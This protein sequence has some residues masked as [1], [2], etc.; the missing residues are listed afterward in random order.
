MTVAQT[1]RSQLESVAPPAK[2]TASETIPSD[3]VDIPHKTARDAWFIM[4]H[5]VLEQG[6]R[7]LDVGC[8]DGA[9]TYAMA[10]MNPGMEYIGLDPDKKKIKSAQDTYRLP[11]LQFLCGDL[12]DSFIPRQSIDA[13]VNAFTLYEIFSDA[14]FS[15]KAVQNALQ[16]QYDLLKPDGQ[17]VIRDHAHP[18]DKFILMEMPDNPGRGSTIA[19][20][21]EPDLLIR[22]SQ[23][24]RS[25]QDESYR[26]FYLEEM[27]ARFPRTRL[28]RLPAKWA[29]EFVLRKN[30]R[31]KWDVELQKE[32][33]FFTEQEYRRT[34]RGLGFRVLYT[35]PHWDPQ[36]VQNRFDKKFKLF[37]EDGTPLGPP[38]TSFM[39]VAVKAA[40]RSSLILQE[41]KPSGNT[42]SALKI[43][44]MRDDVSG[45]LLDVVFRGV[46]TTEILPYRITEDERLMVFVHEGIPRCITNAVP[47]GAPNLDGKR[48]S[49]HM[50]EALSVPQEIVHEI[51]PDDFKTLVRFGQQYLGLKP[52][53][54]ASLEDGPGFYPAPDSIDERIE[55]KYLRVDNH[56]KTSALPRVI[57]DVDGFSTRG[58]LREIDAQIILN[59]IGVGLIPSSRLEIQILGLYQKHQIAYQSWSECPLNLQS[60]DIESTTKLDNIVNKLAMK[61]HRFKDVRG[62]AGQLKSVTS[63]FVDEGQ[64]QA[65]AVTG[66]ASRDVGFVVP[67]QESL[68]LAVILPLTK[69]KSGEVMAGMIEQFLPVPQRYKGNGY[70]VSC[71]SLPLPKDITN[72]ELARKYIAEKFEVPIDC[73]AK[74]GESYFCHAGVTPRRIYPFAVT[75]AGAMSWMKKGR[76]HGPTQ[77]CPLV[78]LNKLLYLDNYDSF[79]KVVALAYTYT[80]GNNSEMSP[81]RAFSMSKVDQLSKPIA[82]RSVEVESIPPKPS[83]Q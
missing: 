10:V 26:G 46:E 71:P 63:I 74:M 44:A 9:V 16:K 15:E 43:S 33:A 52:A 18:D 59:A 40:E 6:S 81:L 22:Y 57:D 12:S 31:D 69:T 68:N 72:M 27:P 25:G 8:G 14:G 47:R 7:I 34:L 30:D 67:E 21:G 62:T 42:R 49:G 17:M 11:N 64:T 75:A 60:E 32:Y 56:V 51:K 39:A 83:R 77:L 78:D 65:G 3:I 29:M 48:W 55:T 5:L 79:M 1:I 37:D 45:R 61:D 54:G 19:D 66:L 41:R 82:L 50:T 53:P 38:P 24:A 35:A 13:I 36:I 70:T 2:K 28:F 23:Q 58:R 20:M 4:A 80:I 76:T 73:V